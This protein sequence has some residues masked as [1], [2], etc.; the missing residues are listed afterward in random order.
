MGIGMGGGRGQHCHSYHKV[1]QP[2]ACSRHLFFSKRTEG[3]VHFMLK[4]NHVPKWDRAIVRQVVVPG[5]L[6]PQLVQLYASMV[7]NAFQRA[8]RGLRH[9]QDPDRPNTTAAA[10]AA[11]A[12][13]LCQE[14]KQCYTGRREV[15][16][17]WGSVLIQQELLLLLLLLLVL[18]DDA[19]DSAVC[20][21]IRREVDPVK[22][23]NPGCTS[24][25]ETGV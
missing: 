19:A 21:I 9:R 24:N 17:N 1:V 22:A 13:S 8:H 4:I 10:A 3:F 15:I 6:R 23:R 2:N 5:W 16:G 18:Q 11:T 7:S 25:D 20:P 14:F 12:N